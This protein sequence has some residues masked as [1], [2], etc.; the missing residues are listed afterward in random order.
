[1]WWLSLCGLVEFH[2]KSFKETNHSLTCKAC[3][4]FDGLVMPSKT[5]ALAN[6]PTVLAWMHELTEQNEQTSMQTK[7]TNKAWM[8]LCWATKLTGEKKKIDKSLKITLCE[9][10]ERGCWETTQLK[11]QKKN[12]NR[13]KMQ[14]NKSVNE[15]E[16][17]IWVAKINLNT[18]HSSV[19][20]LITTCWCNDR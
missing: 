12:F 4:C 9:W 17:K 1:M 3:N 6:I 11:T 13:Q 2:N 7:R 10:L 15:T 19:D 14:L 18:D 20:F 8:M 5:V 16:Q